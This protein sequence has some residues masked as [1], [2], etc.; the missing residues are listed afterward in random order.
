VPTRHRSPNKTSL[1]ASNAPLRTVTIHSAT[2]GREDEREQ[3]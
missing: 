2:I 1:T 3:R